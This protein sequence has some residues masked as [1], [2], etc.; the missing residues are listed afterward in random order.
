MTKPIIWLIDTSILCN[1]LD[2]PGF[3]QDRTEI[4]GEFENRISSGDLFFLPFVVFIETGNHIAQ[5]SGNYKYEFAQK[6]V[7]LVK[8][9]LNSEAPFK[10]LRFPEKDELLRIIDEFP[11]FAGKGIGF[12]DFSII[13]DW[14]DQTSKFMAYSV[15][16]WSLDSGL[17][18]YES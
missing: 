6:F 17:Q 2:L 8:Q 15:R 16:I 18:G 12:G 9:A 7:H 5:L 13:E 4:L 11:E 14:K 1:I 3:N 10:P